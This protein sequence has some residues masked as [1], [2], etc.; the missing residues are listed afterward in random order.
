M[1]I[2]EY[3]IF[4]T[5]RKKILQFVKI[6]IKLLLQRGHRRFKEGNDELFIK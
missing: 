4:R 2:T 6:I 1:I 5:N 3:T